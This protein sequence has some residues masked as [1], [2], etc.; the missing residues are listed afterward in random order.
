MDQH[1]YLISGPI[2]LDKRDERLWR[3]GQ[4]VRLGGKALALLRALMERPQTLVTKD[5]LFDRVWP[6]LA[7]SESVLTTA[8][9]EI[10]QAIGDDARR[11]QI[12]QTVYG[13]GYRFLPDVEPSDE[14]AGVEKSAGER[15]NPWLRDRRIWFGLG[16]LALLVAAVVMVFTRTGG[17]EPS[18]T[19]AVAAHPKS[20]A[21][22]PFGDLS[23]K[24]DQGWFA[25]GLTEEILNS[26]ARTPDLH[27]AAR[28]STMSIRGGDIREIGRRLNVAHI[29]E[30]SVRRD[31]DR[32]RV[33]AQLIRASDGFHLW[34]QNYDRPMSDA[35]TIQEDIAFAIAHAMKTVM[36]PESLQA[37]VQLGT[38]SVEAYEEYLK[39]LA[40]DRRSLETG[41]DNFG[42]MSA[43]ALER[44][45]A[46]DPGFAAAQWEAA[47]YWFGNATRV[48]AS[49]TERRGS[50]GQRLKEY[51][52][53]V[54]AAIAS[55][56]GRP[57]NFKY[58]SARALMD[59]RFREALKLMQLYLRE[60]PR[61]V[62]AWE[63]VV[64][65]AGYAE[66]RR[67][68]AQAAERIHTLS[69]EGGQPLS[70]ALTASVLS[71]DIAN[72]VKRSREQLR[73]S[74]GE[75]LIQYQSH[76]ALLWGGHKDEARA[77]LERIRGS[78][79]PAENILLA[80]LRQACADGGKGAV[81]IAARLASSSERSS[82]NAWHAA[83]LF[84]D[85]RRAAEI[86]KPLDQPERL[87]T[88]MQ[89]LV[90]PEFDVRPFPRLQERLRADGI[91]RR[92]P[93]TP[94]FAC[95]AKA[96]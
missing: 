16:A 34:S 56:Q 10:R 87:T 64:D 89:Y 54:D 45:R 6:G 15:S 26:L 72:A 66:D 68:M 25:E 78:S 59:L 11:P 32:L 73:R 18:A 83:I 50:E 39:A 31:G 5:E 90:Y 33:T 70:R 46:I 62:D 1:R 91:Q 57:E 58:R 85:Q 43:E 37:M 86:L 29:L 74:P 76:R 8:V 84:S 12:I 53:R 82:S 65:L 55:S 42:R 35:V 24:R 52:A 41:D 20:I 92:P 14:A 60:R 27:V 21:V 93:V 28:T 81:E 3:N 48:G 23:A 2:R 30:G 95:S 80:E 77:I 69:L 19:V 36:A 96:A 4:E 22:L 47:Q 49:Q 79:L 94:P 9:K 38:R 71:L 44:A 13:R 7:V 51:L 17:P 75:A 67:F 40:Y 63:E 88:L 61:D